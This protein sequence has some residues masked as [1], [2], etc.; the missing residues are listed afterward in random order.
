L[1]NVTAAAVT[2]V[3]CDR[4]FNSQSQGT[5]NNRVCNKANAKQ[6]TTRTHLSK[7]VINLTNFFALPGIRTQIDHL[8][9]DRSS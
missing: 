4:C 2:S 9:G 6:L 7:V 3:N 8:Q 5:T 1:Y